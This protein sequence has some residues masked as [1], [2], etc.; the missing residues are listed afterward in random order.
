MIKILK[1]LEGER[2]RERNLEMDREI[3]RGREHGF[4]SL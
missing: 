1:E 4:T 3:M 2:E